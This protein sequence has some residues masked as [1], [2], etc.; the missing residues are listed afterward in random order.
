MEMWHE[1]E[2]FVS[3]EDRKFN[4]KRFLNFYNTVKPNKGLNGSTPSEVLDF[5][6]RPEV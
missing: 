6:F 3:S 2:G 1:K 4:L 5:Y